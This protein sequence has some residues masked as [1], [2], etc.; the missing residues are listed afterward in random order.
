MKPQWQLQLTVSVTSE[1]F[2]LNAL[3]FVLAA[4]QFVQ[5][6][7]DQARAET[8]E[9]KIFEAKLDKTLELIKQFKINLL[10]DL[11]A[12]RSHPLPSFNSTVTSL[13]PDEY[14]ISPTT[15]ARNQEAVF[16]I[17]MEA[18]KWDMFNDKSKSN[19]K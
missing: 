10:K 19:Q 7:A 4:T 15:E 5:P 14:K 12:S 6:T 1:W 9:K 16:K 2:S 8:D 13:V 18:K 17:Q 11:V 3:F